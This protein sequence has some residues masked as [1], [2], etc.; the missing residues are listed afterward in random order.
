[1]VIHLKSIENSRIHKHLLCYINQ[2]KNRKVEN[3]STKS[4]K[5]PYPEQILEEVE[6]VTQTSW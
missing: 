6:P 2:N 3:K 5:W 4:T 1:M